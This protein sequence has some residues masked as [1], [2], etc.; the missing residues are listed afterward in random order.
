MS[1]SKKLVWDQTGQKK[2]ETGVEQCALYLQDD[3]GKYPKGVAWNGI[4][5]VSEAPS[6]AEP[7]NIY[8]DNIKYLSLMS[9]EEFGAT[10]TAYMYPDEFETCIGAEEIAEGVIVAQQD[11]AIFGIA[12]KTLIGNDTKQTK[13]GYK[14]HLVYGALTKPSNV[15]R[16]TVNDS[17]EAAEMSWEISTTP[18]AVP[19]KKPTAHLT[20]DSTKM[21]SAKLA[22]IESILYGSEDTDARLPLPE[23]IISIL[24]AEA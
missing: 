12:Y 18:V 4:T 15:D 17:P 5:G 23:E 20:L 7:T 6:G 10:I 14:L 3:N 2:Y 24:Q 1:E 22:K 19:G 16:K 21:D 8:A 13:F 9:A 11:H